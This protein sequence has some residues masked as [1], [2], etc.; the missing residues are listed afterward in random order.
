MRYVGDPVAFVVAETLD[1]AKDAAEAIEVDYET[2]PAV[3]TLE[4]AIAPGA[5]A[6]WDGCPDNLAFLHELGDKAAVDAGVRRGRAR[7]HATAW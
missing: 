3:A 7:R 1:Q 2:L 4:E 6:V 5:P